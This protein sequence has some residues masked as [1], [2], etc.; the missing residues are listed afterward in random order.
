MAIEA[1]DIRQVWDRVRDDIEQIRIDGDWDWKPEDVYAAC[2]NGAAHIYMPDDDDYGF[3]VVQL[4][5]SPFSGEQG[6]F[7]WIAYSPD[8]Q[9]QEKFGHEVEALARGVGCSFITFKSKR[10][11]FERRGGWRVD[12]VVYRKEV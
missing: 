4:T 5:E 9:A 2:V 6:L 12:H 1:V 11:G 10:K 8:G 3:I 7:V